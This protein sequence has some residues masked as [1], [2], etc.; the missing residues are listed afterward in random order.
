[1]DGKN[2]KLNEYVMMTTEQQSV[3]TLL[4]NLESEQ[5]VSKSRLGAIASKLPQVLLE[6]TNN[7]SNTQESSFY[8]LALTAFLFSCLVYLG[9]DQEGVEQMI[10]NPSI[11]NAM[12]QLVI[13][14]KEIEEVSKTDTE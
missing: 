6:A 10:S 1:M 2:K 7:R 13:M 11:I 3:L 5:Q 12:V 9:T 4:E 14:D 8:G